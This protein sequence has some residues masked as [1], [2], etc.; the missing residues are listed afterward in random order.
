MDPNVIISIVENDLNRQQN[1]KDRLA[2]SRNDAIAI[3]VSL[4]DLDLWEKFNEKTNE[5][6]VTKGGR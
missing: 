2:N 1:D 4:Q 3:D 5:M 6:I